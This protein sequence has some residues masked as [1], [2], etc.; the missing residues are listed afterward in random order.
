MINRELRTAAIRTYADTADKYGQKRKGS[1]TDRT[2]NATFGLYQHSKVED[3]R[4]NQVSHYALTRD[5]TITDANTFLIE[6]T[7]YSILFV[8]PVGR[9]TQLFMVKK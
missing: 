8:N 4:F 3:I 9:M 7:E 6:D 2:I 5:K 1:F